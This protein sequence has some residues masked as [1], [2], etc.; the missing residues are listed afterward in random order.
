M[1]S[2]N[3]GSMFPLMIMYM[4]YMAVY[5]IL[6]L[7]LHSVAD[8]PGHLGQ[9]RQLV[10][11]PAGVQSYLHGRRSRSRDAGHGRY[12]PHVTGGTLFFLAAILATDEIIHNQIF[13]SSVNCNV[14]SMNSCNSNSHVIYVLLLKIDAFVRMC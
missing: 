4:L 11:L 3:K 6:W 7:V 10:P 12:P 1:S 9:H 5:C 8:P 14:T 13:E 2:E